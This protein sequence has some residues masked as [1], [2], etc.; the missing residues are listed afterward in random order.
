A[1]IKA[2]LDGPRPSGSEVTIVNQVDFRE[3]E[4]ELKLLPEADNI[5][6]GFDLRK[7]APG[8]KRASETEA[9]RTYLL[10]LNVVAV[11]TNVEAAKPGIGQNKEVLV[12]KLVG[13]GE[14]LTE[15]AREEAAL[16]DKLDD[17]IRRLTDVDNKLRSLAARL[18]GNTQ[19]EQFVADQTRSNE[20]VE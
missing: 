2:R 7:V 15:I 4:D 11:D 19:P 20:L 1:E 9:Q 8:L 18:P 5:R 10:N 13:D 16:A 6:Y 3:I 12:F 14:L 17:A